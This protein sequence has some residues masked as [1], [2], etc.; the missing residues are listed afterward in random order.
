MA[1]PVHAAA[2]DY[3]IGGG[4]VYLR[5]TRS[6]VDLPRGWSISVARRWSALSAVVQADGEYQ[7]LPLLVGEAGISLHGIMAGGRLSG[8]IG[9]VREFVEVLGGAVRGQGVTLGT[10]SDETRGAVQAGIGV[11]VPIGRR[12]AARLQFDGRAFRSQD[13]KVTQ[14]R[15]VAG[16]AFAFH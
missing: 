4:Y 3:E 11:D 15:V 13:W 14:I 2:Q 1:A 10:A 12:L 8:R 6:D 5:D 16:A 9:R 7:T